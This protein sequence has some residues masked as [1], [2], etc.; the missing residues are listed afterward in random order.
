MYHHYV[1]D[2]LD[3]HIYE[4]YHWPAF[5]IADVAIVCGVGIMLAMMVTENHKRIHMA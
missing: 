3:F 5:N 1:I 4:K 2:F